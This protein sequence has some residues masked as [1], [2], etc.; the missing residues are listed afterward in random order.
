MDYLK[1][2]RGYWKLKALY[3]ELT[4]EGAKNVLVIRT[5]TTVRW[6]QN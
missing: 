4:L 3:G 5:D 6:L 1:E 2:I